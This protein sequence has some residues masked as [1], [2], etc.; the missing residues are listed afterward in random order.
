MATNSP[1]KIVAGVASLTLINES[2]E[3]VSTEALE[4]YF[5]TIKECGITTIDTAR[6]YPGSEEGI[7]LVST[8]NDFIID[9]KLAGGFVPGSLTPE[10]ILPDIADSLSKVNIRQFDILYIHAPDPSADM[11]GVAAKL[12]EAHKNGSFRRL[13]LSN[14]T[15]EQVQETYDIC[16]K[17]D[18][19]LP[20]VYQ[21]NYSAFVRHAETGLFPV[22]RKLNIAF[23]V[24][25]PLAGG[26]L[27]KTPE[28]LQHGV[29]RHNN[30]ALQQIYTSMFNRPT[31]RAA[32][33]KWAKIAEEEGVSKA[34]LAYRWVAYDGFLK[35]ELGDAVIMGARTEEMV[36][37]AAAWLK[38]GGLSAKAKESIDRLWE[39]VKVENL[40]DN[41]NQDKKPQQ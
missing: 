24:Y 14:F 17:N 19:V 16:K 33:E 18:Y 2:S 35:A 28:E 39:I 38:K 31:F 21:G 41:Y 29:R 23:Y 30:S 32:L 37:E 7:G 26:V 9:D 25:S 1:I 8:R 4:S 34:E 3:A 27:T 36:R 11:E 5:N 12:N 10:N 40:V 22:L 20:S 15:A 6:I 13:G